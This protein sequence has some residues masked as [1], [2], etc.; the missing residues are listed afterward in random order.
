MP[1]EGFPAWSTFPF[2]WEL[3]FHP[4]FG[5]G[6]VSLVAELR[7]AGCF[8]SAEPGHNKSR[9]SALE[10]LCQQWGKAY[11]CGAGLFIFHLVPVHSAA[12]LGIPR[13]TN[14]V[15]TLCFVRS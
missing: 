11:R 15:C 2:D 6:A 10:S 9:S 7:C 8:R 14:Q 13:R 12:T 5:W 4:G 1:E 3:L